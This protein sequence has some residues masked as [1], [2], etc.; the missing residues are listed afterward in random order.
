[1]FVEV[2]III[3]KDG[4]TSFD[5]S[6][7]TPKLNSLPYGEILENRKYWT[8]DKYKDDHPILNISEI[9]SIHLEMS[10]DDYLRVIH[11][12]N[13]EINVKVKTNFTF[14]NNNIEERIEN[15]AFR[16]KGGK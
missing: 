5:C 8:N 1:V 4:F 7:R 15:V 13:R 9:A 16:L 11:P 10:W 14:I 2:I 12:S 6:I 3:K